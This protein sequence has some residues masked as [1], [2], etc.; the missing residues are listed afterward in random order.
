MNVENIYVPISLVNA[1][2]C[3]K[4][5]PFGL[6]LI[7]SLFVRIIKLITTVHTNNPAP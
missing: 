3:D 7:D 4:I 2:M 6:M 1:L 5:K